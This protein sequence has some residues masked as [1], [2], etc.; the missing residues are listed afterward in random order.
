MQEATAYAVGFATSKYAERIAG[1]TQAEVSLLHIVLLRDIQFVRYRVA[2]IISF[3]ILT[4]HILVPLLLAQVL[5][6]S[7]SQLEKIFGQLEQKHMSGAHPE[8]ALPPS[9]LPRASSVYLGGMYWD[10]QPGHH[11]YIGGGYCSPR[12]N[13]PINSG[14]CLLCMM[15]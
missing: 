8:A 12:V 10:W 3:P 4:L 5:A 2:K 13:K 1:M 6:A 14:E 11:K 9:S 7:V 15:S